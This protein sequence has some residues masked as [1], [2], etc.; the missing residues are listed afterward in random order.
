MSIAVIYLRTSKTEA[1][2]DPGSG[3]PGLYTDPHAQPSAT[4]YGK[5]YDL[6]LVE[7]EEALTQ[8][9][10]EICSSYPENKWQV[11]HSDVDLWTSGSSHFQ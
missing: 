7:E 4:L 8:N 10:K 2:L 3:F 6:H 9:K 5:Y 1:N 11:W